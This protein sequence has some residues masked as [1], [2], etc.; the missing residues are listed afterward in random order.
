MALARATDVAALTRRLVIL[1]TAAPGPGLFS[2]VRL[3][4]DR[5]PRAT[6][7]FIRPNAPT[8]VAFFDVLGLPFLFVGVCAL[9]ASRHGR[10]SSSP[11]LKN[12][13]KTGKTTP[14]RCMP[15]SFAE[16]EIRLR[17]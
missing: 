13:H 17:H 6:L 4:V 7:G 16:V 3:G 15:I 14:A 2:A 5:R 10:S 12:V 8:L 1:C 11:N 9:I